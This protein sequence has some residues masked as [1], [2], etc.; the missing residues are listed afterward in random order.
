MS[1]VGDFFKLNPL[2]WKVGLGIALAAAVLIG[3][4]QFK[5]YGLR[6]TVSDRDVTIAQ[7][8]Q[9]LT[10]MTADRDKLKLKIDEQNRAIARLQTDSQHAATD[11]ENNALKT[12]LDGQASRQAVANLPGTGP[13]VQNKWLAQEFQ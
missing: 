2:V 12:A 5:I 13:E 3:V 6:Q 1:V 10:D 8:A 7:G 9:K 11:A 4:Q